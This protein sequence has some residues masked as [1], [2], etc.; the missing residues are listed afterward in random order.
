M[1]IKKKR[2]KIK[3]PKYWSFLYQTKTGKNIFVISNIFIKF[4]I[5]MIKFGIEQP[6]SCVY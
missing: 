3:M 5:V 6:V 4:K 1:E 2:K